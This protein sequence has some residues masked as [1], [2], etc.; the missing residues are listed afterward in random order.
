MSS[1]F[2]RILLVPLLVVAGMSTYQLHAR[3]SS[4]VTTGAKTHGERWIPNPPDEVATAQFL[5]DRDAY[6]AELVAVAA[7]LDGLE[8]ARLAAEAEAARQAAQNA[9]RTVSRASVSTVTGQCGGATNGADQYIARES[10]GNPGI[11]NTGGSGAWG[12]YQI[13]PGTWA[14]SC[15]DL[16]QH[17]T[18]SPAAQAAC[19]SRLPLSAWG[20]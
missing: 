6:F 9:T 13:M 4:G 5:A 18:A 11:Y 10:G 15:S 7:Y 20:G 19:A 16:G 1:S 8:A 12:C 17:G 14:S 2:P 3:E